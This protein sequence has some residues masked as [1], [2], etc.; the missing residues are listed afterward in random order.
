[1]K[2]DWIVHGDEFAKETHCHN[3]IW[4]MCWS[5]TNGWR[6]NVLM[7]LYYFYYGKVASWRKT[8]KC[9]G[10][11]CVLIV[12]DLY[13]S[14][15]Y[16][17]YHYLSSLNTILIL[18]WLQNLNHVLQCV[19]GEVCSCLRAYVCLS[20]CVHAECVCGVCVCQGRRSGYESGGDG[21]HVNPERILE[22]QTGSHRAKRA[23]FGRGVRGS[24]PGKFQKPTWQMVQSTLF[25]SYF[26]EYY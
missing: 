25:L 24:S 26:C 14:V 15:Q 6:V 17:A 5:R 18:A 2:A 16:I 10:Q 12:F 4:W 19:C 13:A 23:N 7:V 1:M 20:A 22:G 8:H 3:D 11:I 21:I 9:M